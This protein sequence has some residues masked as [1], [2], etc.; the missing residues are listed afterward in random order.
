MPFP[1]LGDGVFR[2]HTMEISTFCKEQGGKP[3]FSLSN[4]SYIFMRGEIN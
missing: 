1:N 3:S 2:I 4:L